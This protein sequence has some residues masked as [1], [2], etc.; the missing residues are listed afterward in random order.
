MRGFGK[1]QQWV[2]NLP[3][4]YADFCPMRA[5]A[6]T[7]MPINM[8]IPPIRMVRERVDVYMYP[9]VAVVEADFEFENL[10]DDDVTIEV[11]FPTIGDGDT[12][13]SVEVMLAFKAFANGERVQVD[14]SRIQH[15]EFPAWYVWNQTFPARKITRLRAEYDTPLIH[16]HWGGRMPFSYIL[17]TGAY[18]QGTIG[19]A[20][21][22]IHAKGIPLWAIRE[23]T[24][25][26]WAIDDEAGTL[27]WEFHDLDPKQDIGLLLSPMTIEAALHGIRLNCVMGI[28]ALKPPAGTTV[29]V[30][31]RH[32]QF[33]RLEDLEVE[34]FTLFSERF[35][36]YN[37]RIPDGIRDYRR[38]EESSVSIPVVGDRSITTENYVINRRDNYFS[39]GQLLIKGTV[40]YEDGEPL[41]RAIRML[42][43][44]VRPSEDA[45][46][47]KPNPIFEYEP[48]EKRYPD[49]LDDTDP[50][51][52]ASEMRLKLPTR[53]TVPDFNTPPKQTKENHLP[54]DRLPHDEK[55]LALEPLPDPVLV[56]YNEKT[57]PWHQSRPIV[58]RYDNDLFDKKP[59]VLRCINNEPVPAGLPPLPGVPKMF[60]VRVEGTSALPDYAPGD[61]LLAQRRR[62]E[63]KEGDVVIVVR[64]GRW[65]LSHA[66]RLEP[67]EDPYPRWFHDAWHDRRFS[68]LEV[69][70]KIV[71]RLPRFLGRLARKACLTD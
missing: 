39:Y 67:S 34:R 28:K 31:G 35:R 66:S 18:W 10:S 19:E 9:H 59:L 1:L 11:G 8:N 6:S 36:D 48:P 20:I 40:E 53:S 38:A 13:Y 25:E 56:R 5:V 7:M 58:S 23:A 37:F 16:Y 46:F 47:L 15:P 14:S 63:T 4:A 42:D 68:H 61:L 30:A 44:L 51:V 52:I 22:Q 32:E 26:G 21:V 27:T 70:A 41:I 49:L 64:D 60:F 57:V 55:F 2:E 29:W 24:P 50:L 65:I 33:G 69:I 62:I 45:W 43:R 3:V 71:C 12:I 17:R 54:D